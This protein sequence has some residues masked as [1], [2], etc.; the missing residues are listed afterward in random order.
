MP[1]TEAVFVGDDYTAGTE[2][3]LSA[4]T[5]VGLTCQRLQWICNVDAESGTG[6]VN[7]GHDVKVTH[8]PYLDRLAYTA[9]TY[10]ADVVVVSGG[11]NDGASS[12]ST[13]AI[14]AYFRAVRRSYPEAKVVALGPFW[15]DG[16]PPGW[17]IRQRS[18]V[19]AAADSNHACYVD[20]DG[21]LTPD[22]VTEGT[23][24]PTADGQSAIAGQLVR[25]L[26]N[27]NDC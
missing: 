1:P 11:R 5:F 3:L 25:E 21:W 15:D 20:T 24:Q 14:G 10:A 8:S 18:S 16:K 27:P 9:K 13:D 23:I 17:L 22:L 4:D 6:Y 26:K 19:R 7:N 2:G 12:K